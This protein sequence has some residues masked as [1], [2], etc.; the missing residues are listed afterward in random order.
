MRNGK[1]I[2]AGSNE[3]EYLAELALWYVGGRGDWPRS[4]PPMQSGPE[5]IKKYDPDGYKLVDD[6]VSGRLDVK[7]TTPRPSR[8]RGSR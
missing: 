6:L 4:M 3:N 7:P 5:F 8:R 1:P 2:Y